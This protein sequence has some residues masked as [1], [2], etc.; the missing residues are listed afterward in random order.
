VFIFKEI[1]MTVVVGITGASGSVYAVR[2]LEQLALVENLKVHVVAST[3][4][5]EVVEFE[6]NKKVEDIAVKNNFILERCDNLFSPIASGSYP[7]DATVIVPCS[8]STIGHMAG[9]ATNNLLHRAGM[10]SLKERRKTI[11]AFRESPL[12]SIDLQNMLTLSQA[13]AIIMPLAP[14]FYHKPT[15]YDEIVDSVVGKILDTVGIKNNMY[16]K[17]KGI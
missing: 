3:V 10:V 8:M 9:G 15:T 12:S 11:L 6:A 4:G 14:G 16:D 1:Y 2:L 13:G 7:V 17:W 5:A